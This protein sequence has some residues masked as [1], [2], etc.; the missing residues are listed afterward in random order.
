M[1]KDKKKLPERKKR[2]SSQLKLPTSID[3]IVIKTHLKFVKYNL[4]CSKK[5]SKTSQNLDPNV[6]L[7]LHIHEDA[8]KILMG[9]R[10]LTKT[11]V[12]NL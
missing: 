10:C 7:L 1:T 2:K 4:W 3:S 8:D 5:R 12:I 6:V 9:G 11:H